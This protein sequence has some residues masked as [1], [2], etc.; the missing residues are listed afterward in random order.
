MQLHPRLSFTE[1]CLS[2]DKGTPGRE[3]QEKDACSEEE[4]SRLRYSIRLSSSL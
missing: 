4:Q 2:R 1:W 3:R